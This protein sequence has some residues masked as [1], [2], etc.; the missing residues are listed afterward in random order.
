MGWLCRRKLEIRDDKMKIRK[1]YWK[2]QSC[3]CCCC[4]HCIFHKSLDIAEQLTERGRKCSTHVSHQR[5][6]NRVVA[7]V[8]VLR[9]VRNTS[10][11]VDF[12]DASW[13]WS[14]ASNS[15]I[16]SHTWSGSSGGGSGGDLDI[17][18]LAA[19]GIL[20]ASHSIGTEEDVEFV[21]L[22]LEA[23]WN[24]MDQ[25]LE[26]LRAAYVLDRWHKSGPWWKRQEQKPGWWTAFLLPETWW[27]CAELWMSVS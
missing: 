25:K 2:I 11:W 12:V 8:G 5:V 6:V 27:N 4:F 7:Q 21:D 18:Q 3:C 15:A 26:N 14:D 20:Q 13:N 17:S 10:G 23:R 9:A 24:E 1:T 16:R 22:R 19:S